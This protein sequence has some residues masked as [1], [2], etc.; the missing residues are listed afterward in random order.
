MWQPLSTLL[1]FLTPRGSRTA[2]HETKFSVGDPNGTDSR[3]GM[4][5]KRF[6][7][8]RV[9]WF[10]W[11]PQRGS[12]WEPYSCVTLF[13]AVDDVLRDCK[14]C[15]VGP[16]GDGD[17]PDFLKVPAGA[18]PWVNANT[19]VL[20]DVPGP[21]AVSVGYLLAATGGYQPVCTFDNWPNEKG[22]LK[23]EAVIGRLLHYAEAMTDARR[24]K[25]TVKSPP[26]WLCDANRLTGVKPRPGGF[27]NRYFIEDRLL[28]GAQVLRRAGITRIVYVDVAPT[29]ARVGNRDVLKYLDFIS[30]QGIQ[31]STVSVA[32]AESWRTPENYIRLPSDGTGMAADYT[33]LIRS[34]AGGFGGIV[35]EQSSG[36]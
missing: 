26:A 8:A 23:P 9:L 16:L 12:P 31:V 29:A 34:S 7:A 5:W 21:L 11:A 10:A 1:E 2:S 3:L 27:D 19:M 36:G 6:L 33:D 25:L 32:S 4:G 35:P 15:R 17:V 13:A 30:T 14:T 20:V 24:E 18:P 22:V 28:P